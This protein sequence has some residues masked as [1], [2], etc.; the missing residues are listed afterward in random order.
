MASDK[1]IE[2]LS[3]VAANHLFLG[4]FEPLRAS[5]LSLRKR[6]P[7]L[8]SSFLH[9]I[10]SEGG[11]VLGVHWSS[12]CPSSSHLAW[13]ASLELSDS[14]ESNRLGVEFLIL[15]Q[16]VLFKLSEDISNSEERCMN[17]LNKILNLGLKRLKGEINQEGFSEDEL[18]FL[19]IVIVKYAELFDAICE[20]IRKQIQ[21]PGSSD[22]NCVEWIAQVQRTVQLAHLSAIKEC[23]EKNDINGACTHLPFLHLNYGV[24]EEM[25]KDV[26][27]EIVMKCSYKSS[28][29]QET[30]LESRKKLSKIYAS[31]LHSSS[32]KL[33][34]MIQLIQDE[35]LSEEIKQNEVSVSES[36]PL[37][38]K[39]LLETFPYKETND[40]LKFCMRDLYHY[41]RVCEKHELELIV[42]TSLSL[43]SKEKLE[44]ASDVI[45]IFPLLY[46][47]IAVL[48]WDL[49]S[50]KTELRQKLMKLFW[51][52]K[53]DILKSEKLSIHETQNHQV[54]LVDNLCE[55]LC[56]CLDVAKYVA[57]Q[58]GQNSSE[59]SDSDF[60][61]PFVENLVLERLAFQ[62]PLRVIFDSVPNIKCKDAIRFIESQ[63][64]SSNSEAQ[65]RWRDMELVHMCYAVESVVFA[66][67]LIESYSD[68]KENNF[69]NAMIY[70]KKMKFHMECIKDTSRKIFMAS[71][72]SSLLQTDH[73]SIQK[74]YFEIPE[75][76]I[77]EN[78]IPE[79]VENKIPGN[80]NRTVISFLET[81]LKILRH[82]ISDSGSE[83]EHAL[84]AGPSSAAKPALDWRLSSVRNCLGDFEW[85][86]SLL[87]R[88]KPLSAWKEALVILRD[89]PSKLLNL[90]MKMGEYE[91]GNEIVSRFSLPHEDKFSLQLAKWTASA[92]RK[93]DL[94]ISS[95]KAQLGPLA[96]AFLFI[97][98]AVT[99]AKSRETCKFLLDQA[100]KILSE[101]NT[102]NL[103][104]VGP[105]YW[106]QIQEI[107]LI[108]LSKKAI[109]SLQQLLDSESS[110]SIQDALTKDPSVSSNDSTKL[111]QNQ[112]ALVLLHQMID[113]AFKGKTQFL[114]GKLHNLAKVITDE[115]SN[116]NKT[117]PSNNKSVILG[118]GFQ[119]LN[120]VSKSR[121]SIPG[122]KSGTSIPG[123]E[124]GSEIQ[125]TG[126]RIFSSVPAKPSAYLSNFII[127]I[128]TVGD[129]FDGTDTTH[130]FNYF[131]LIY[132]SPRELLTHLVFERK[133]TDAAEE[134]SEILNVD[135][136]HEIISSCVPPV[137]IPKSSQGWASMPVL[138][139]LTNNNNNSNNNS[140]NS[141]NFSP[142]SDASYKSAFA[143]LERVELYPLQLGVVRQLANLSPVRA[144]LACVFGSSI[145]SGDSETEWSFYEFALEQSERFPTLNRWIQM[146][147]NLH[148]VSE[149]NTPK[150]STGLKKEKTGLKRA[151][152]SEIDIGTEIIPDLE[153]LSDL[154]SLTPKH[155][156]FDQT[157]LISFDWENEAPYE[158]AV[159]RLISEGKLMDALAVSDRCLKN[160]A[161]DK[162]LQLLIEE[163]GE[164]SNNNNS[165]NSATSTCQYCLRL[166]DKQLASQLALKYLHKWNLDDAINVLTMCIC[167]LSENDPMW[168][169]VYQKRQALRRYKS[170]LSADDRHSNWQEVEAA[171]KEDGEG[172]ALRL[173]SKGNVSA[174]L[175]VSETSSLST[176]FRRELQG[177]QLVKLLTTDPLSGGGPASASRFLSSLTD[178][179]DA[180]P[181]AVGAMGLL[182]DLRSKQL[183]V[184]FFLKRKVGNLSE[185]DLERLN[186]WALGLR[187][188]ALLPLP[189]QQ[190]CSNL[191]EHPRLILEVLLMMKQLQSASLVLK[192]FPS[193]RDDTLIL[194]YAKKSISVNTTSTPRETRLSISTSRPKQKKPGPTP[195]SPRSG[196][197]QSI[198]GFQKRAL[199]WVSQDSFGSCPAGKSGTAGG[200]PGKEELRKRKSSILGSPERAPQEES[201]SGFAEGSERVQVLSVS[202][203]W[204]LTGDPVRDAETRSA[205]KYDSSPDITLFKALLS[206]CYDESVAAKG[207][208]ELCI[209]Q[210]QIV[211]SSQNLPS[212]SS[213]E[214]MSR[215]YHAT[216][217]Y[218]QGLTFARSELRKLCES[219][220]ISSSSEKG[221]KTEGEY[222]YNASSETGSSKPGIGIPD[223][224]KIGNGNPDELADLLGQAEIWLGR[225]ELLQSLLGSNISASLDDLA[226]KESSV[227]LRDRLVKDERYSM[228]IYTCKKCKIDAFPVWK[229]WGLALIR[230]EHYAQARVK[231]K[232][233]M[234]LYK[235]ENISQVVLEIISTVESGPPVD[236]SSVRSMYEHS[237]KSAAAIQD[238][239]LSADSYLNILYMPST[240]PRSER[241][242]RSIN[243]SPSSVSDLDQGPRS[244]LDAARYSE[245]LHYLQEYA[246]S[247]T[248]PFMFRHGHYTEACALFLHSPPQLEASSS[249]QRTES[250][251]TDYGSVEELCSLCIDHGAMSSLADCF[252]DRIEGLDVEKEGVLYGYL[253]AVL[254][255]VCGFCET[256]KHFNYL[257]DFLVIRGDRVAAGL[258]CIQLFMNSMSQEEAL[259]HLSNARTHFE[260]ALLGRD[261]KPTSKM[262]SKLVRGKSGT[263]K[264]TNEIIVKFLPRVGL[265]ME[266]VKALNSPEG[267]QW[268]TSL[269]GNPNDPETFKRRCMVVETLAEK[270]FDLAFKALHDFNLPA[271]DIYAGVMTNLGERKRNRDITEFLKNIKGTIDDDDWDQVVSAG[272]SIYVNKHR[273]RPD[274]LVEMLMSSHRKVLACVI[275][276]R[277]KSAFQIASRSGSVA[278]VQ[279]VA[280]QALKSNSQPIV[281][282]CRTWLEQ[283]M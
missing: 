116:G 81:L 25:Y 249:L 2:L 199:S 274:R 93:R 135:F 126:N 52:S 105:T 7:E 137:F 120:P 35:L 270:H 87:K 29:Y 47:L 89:P 142:M 154:E 156:E 195:Q 111:G 103:P 74:P 248:L 56:F 220:Y 134:A 21:E 94:D 75:T 163:T 268:K 185:R 122:P 217:A 165:N 4:Q 240:F 162:L 62:T 68:E 22:N 245:C 55:I 45:S 228:A 63:P 71:I 205:H 49:L 30:W 218:V 130:D 46:P 101:I 91:I 10:V 174:A 106:D 66:I 254:V 273:E 239:S 246:R 178:S 173:A 17:V 203:E 128:A 61:D 26:L 206:L 14:S 69:N 271:V 152:E 95:Y 158:T 250:V 244:N 237:A 257:Y 119:L 230:M 190:R 48:G 19:W 129:I 121:T 242:R 261:N 28:F 43:I 86:L 12:S 18:R 3:R 200:T 161:S 188:L 197:K 72:I 70:L 264:M 166:R 143:E 255:R 96:T 279:Y 57:S 151:R 27:K 194:S 40:L 133:S 117:E 164:E 144:V 39:K 258:C 9:T 202:D 58:N 252:R 204:V 176:S 224:S 73:I 97:D 118:S 160:G 223:C 38:L 183:L 113:D 67:N 59:N 146:Q 24:E 104:K 42:E 90:C 115:D 216:E 88:L 260:E 157:V 277:L 272:I 36:V 50:G 219:G 278:D 172:L 247:E 193:L 123:S 100:K 139:S 184:H 102:K 234:Q 80:E 124:T 64:V 275:C 168:N 79:N 265:Q 145:L 167:H 189:Q 1:E 263:E 201:R 5:L 253:N 232:Q 109:Q 13:L 229:A 187:V 76:E 114:N 226:D 98:G 8:A 84:N 138:P 34:Q 6:R 32:T 51:K 180:L 44:E 107:A 108:S 209:N 31:L 148:R 159:E 236:V 262:V 259:K 211:L 181:V 243:R 191:H 208:L 171:C 186:S 23:L 127:Y 182:P 83:S 179:D 153:N 198:E 266:I 85:R 276:G 65:K 233:A 131:S 147:S 92:S 132:E 241:S 214:I 210:M 170:I 78:K 231:F 150:N 227:M 33:V 125:E 256:H 269:F 177:R 53:S 11:D 141:S 215:A 136:V 112:R 140:N 149:S 60:T 238:D 54:S 192:E 283:F 222:Q 281:E 15:V 99:T 207:A 221:N 155:E 175:Q 267:P 37:P 235:D 196:L 82:S 169:E 110:R 282:M 225:A 212:E 280:H 213:Q 41:S 77:L 20:N 16:S 251:L